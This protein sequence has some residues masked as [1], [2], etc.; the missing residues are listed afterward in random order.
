MQMVLIEQLFNC[1][2]H[3]LKVNI[4]DLIKIASNI[5]NSYSYVAMFKFVH[6]IVVPIKRLYRCKSIVLSLYSKQLNP[7]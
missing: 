3:V 7:N 5:T 2:I 6:K 4:S 1:V